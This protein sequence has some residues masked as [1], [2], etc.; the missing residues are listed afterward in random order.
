MFLG[1]GDHLHLLPVVGEFFSAIKAN[2]IRSR[3]S[4]SLGA[5][6]SSTNRYRKTVARV[7]TAKQRVHQ[8]LDHDPPSTPERVCNP[9]A[10]VEWAPPAPSYCMR[11][12]HLLRFTDSQKSFAL[13]KQANSSAYDVLTHS[14][15]NSYGGEVFTLVRQK[16]L[17][18]AGGVQKIE[19]RGEYPQHWRALKKLRRSAGRASCAA[20]TLS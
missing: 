1:R 5:A 17:L 19:V 12:T 2:H 20:G 18:T 14:A 3:Q 11:C 6:R 15:Q 7:P 13:V 10:V 16:V 9:W 8:F 4:C